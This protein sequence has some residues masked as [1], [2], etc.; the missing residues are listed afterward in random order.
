MSIY[1]VSG[2]FLNQKEFIIINDVYLIIYVNTFVR[3]IV[4]IYLLFYRQR[5]CFET[6]FLKRG[7]DEHS[8]Y[9]NSYNEHA[10][11]FVGA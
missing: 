11:L 7:G 10:C 3:L 1:N 6:N 4:N 9:F 2:S 8:L 5:C